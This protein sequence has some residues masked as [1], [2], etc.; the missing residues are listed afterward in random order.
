MSENVEGIRGEYRKLT[1]FEIGMIVRL[2]RERRGIKRAVLAAD[3]NIS[4]K[5]LERVEGGARVRAESYRRI[6]EALGLNGKMFTTA[7]Y[8]PSSEDRTQRV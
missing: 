6:A 5:T 1:P 3:A 4:E 2:L 7:S 8:I